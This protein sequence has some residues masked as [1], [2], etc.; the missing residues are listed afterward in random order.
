MNDVNLNSPDLKLVRYGAQSP[1]KALSSSQAEGRSAPDL[2]ASS[3]GVRRVDNSQITNEASEAERLQERNEAQREELDQA[4]SQLNDFVQNVQ[5]DLQFE[6]DNEMGQTI[7]K[8]VD[9]QTQEVIRQIP[10]EVALR[11]A[12]KLQQDEPLTLFNIKV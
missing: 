8:V 6:V 2:A 10:D 3:A 11:L 4:V 9:Q 12:E 7:V 5:R 1:A